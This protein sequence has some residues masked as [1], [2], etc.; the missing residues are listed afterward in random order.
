MNKNMPKEVEE[1]IDGILEPLRKMKIL[2]SNGKVTIIKKCPYCERP[3]KN[4]IKN[5]RR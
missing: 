4:N 1:F 2:G 3:F 5:F